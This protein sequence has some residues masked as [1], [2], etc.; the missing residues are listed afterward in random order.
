MKLVDKEIEIT[1]LSE[2]VDLY[3][4]DLSSWALYKVSDSELARDL[5]QETFLAAAE[6]I[7]R[8]K[9]D[10]SP[11]TWLFAILNH[12]IIDHYRSKTR[13]PIKL[14]N[15]LFSQ[16]F[17]QDGDW[18]ADKRPLDWHEEDPKLLDDNEFQAVLK[19][20]LD[21][22]PETWNTCVKLK[23]L[24]NKKGEDICQELDISPTNFWQIVHR[25]KLQLRGCIEENWYKN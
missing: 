9:G 24:M 1:M 10:S 11:K 3:T 20:C 12:K 2:W 8:F 17:D 6:N 5:I 18:K 23:Y 15:Q 13:E 22:L 21:A 19:D 16:F 14:E 7:Q 25:A 4:R